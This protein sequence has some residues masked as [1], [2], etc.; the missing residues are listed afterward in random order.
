MRNQDAELLRKVSVSVH[1]MQAALIVACLGI[2]LFAQTPSWKPVRFRD[3]LLPLTPMQAVAGGEVFVQATVTDAGRVGNVTALRT[4]PPF[5]EYVL[6]AVRGWRFQPAEQTVLR[7][8]GDPRS[9]V[10]EPVEAKAFVGC[11]FRPPTLNTPTLGEPP[12]DVRI[13][14]DDVAFPLSIV[15]PLYPPQANA[16]ATVLIEVT[17]GIDGRVVRAGSLRSTAGFEESALNAARQWTFRPARIHGRLEE[18]FAYLV[19]AFRR[20]VT[21]PLTSP[22]PSPTSP[23]PK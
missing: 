6:D 12:K 21:S 19:F 5:T 7:T 9:M 15:T 1:F 3:G 22:S 20:P 16:D 8:P 10:T 13:A 2:G 4:S 11:V 23:T 17:V 14:S 18:T